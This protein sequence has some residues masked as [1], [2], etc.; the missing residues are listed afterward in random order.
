[1]L[2][3]WFGLQ[4][5]EFVMLLSASSFYAVVLQQSEDFFSPPLRG[6]CV[7]VIPVTKGYVTD[8]CKTQGASGEA[9]KMSACV[10]QRRPRTH[11]PVLS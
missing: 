1:M 11:L 9:G 4:L 6:V 7:C 10:G 5:A 3:A 8:S 2:F